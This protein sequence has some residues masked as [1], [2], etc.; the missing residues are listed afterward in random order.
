MRRSPGEIAAI[1]LAAAVMIL[2]LLLPLL[3]VFTEA[4]AH[5]F[6]TAVASLA[7]PD[8]MAAIRLTLLI[9][10]ICVPLNT[11][12]GIAAA[13]AVAKFDFAGKR[14][15]TLL[16]ELPLT[17]S[18][19]VSGLV[20]VLLFGANGW[21]GPALG[22]AGIQIVFAIPGM[23]LATMFVTFPFVARSLLPLMQ[24][25]GRE[26][27]EAASLLGAGFWP[28]FRRITLPD[29]RWALLAGILLCNARAMGEF[30]AVAVVS[31][32]IPGQTETMPLHI[33]T[34]Y[35]G[36]QSAAAFAMAA[37]LAMLGLLTLAL[38]ALLEWRIGREA[39]APA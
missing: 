21:F 29:M 30:G 8:A 4:L 20:W 26:Q 19:I 18:P 10:A 28:I 11:I 6:G 1:L 14:L 39:G 12:C 24:E 32:H 15:V 16:I 13:W 31:G 34:L 22:R 36:Y 23:V 9:A 35:N 38:K 7:D 17:V 3:T 25:Q 2:M 27:E 33:E 5:G 37:I